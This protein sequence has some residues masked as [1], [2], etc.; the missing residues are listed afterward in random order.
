MHA[1]PQ[2]NGAPHVELDDGYHFVVTERGSELQR[3]MSADRAELLYWIFEAHTF[4]LAAAFELRHRVEGADSRRLLFARQEHLL[5]RVSQ[6]WG[7][8]NTA[9]HRAVLVRHPFDD[10]RD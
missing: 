4:A 6:E 3:R 10:R 1:V 5:G 2:E 9:E 7:L 8:R